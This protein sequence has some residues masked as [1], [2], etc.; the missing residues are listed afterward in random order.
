[1]SLAA[2]AFAATP[3]AIRGVVSGTEFTPPVIANSPGASAASRVAASLYQSAK[4]CLDA[5]DNGVCDAG[6][7]SVLTKA[8]GSFCW[9]RARPV[10][11]SPKFPPRR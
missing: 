2:P 11:C 3:V 5:N 10:R 1:L 6:E 4:V 8:D 9:P 7:T